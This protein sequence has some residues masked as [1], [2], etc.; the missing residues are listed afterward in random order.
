M[1]VCAC[2]FVAANA[3]A[4]TCVH[5]G[6]HGQHMESFLRHC[7]PCFLKRTVTSL[8]IIDLLGQPVGPRNL[9]VSVSP[10]L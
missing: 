8:E 7:P 1:S 4:H 3:C 10:V 5:M 6:D 9:P 2:V